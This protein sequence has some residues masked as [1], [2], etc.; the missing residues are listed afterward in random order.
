ML[1][2]FSIYHSDMNITL[3]YVYIINLLIFRVKGLIFT[4]V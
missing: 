2:R 1:C 3:L 4:N